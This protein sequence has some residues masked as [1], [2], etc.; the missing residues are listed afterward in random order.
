MLGTAQKFSPQPVP[1]AQPSAQ[2]DFM[3]KVFAYMAGG[4]GIT[5]LTAFLVSHSQTA[6]EFLILNRPVFFGLLIA[7][8]LMVF[9]FTGMARRM[10]ASNAGILFYC[11]AILNGITLSVVF[12]LYTQASIASTFVVSAGT[13]GAMS[14]YGFLTKRDLTSF[15][16]F[17]LMGLFGLIL[18]SIVNI[19][20]HSA[21]IYWLT[22]F[23][24]VLVF[25][26][27]TAY[28]VQKI[29][30]LNDGV[31]DSE[32]THKSAIHGALVLYLD[33]INM[34]LY[35]LRLLGRRR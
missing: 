32:Q 3:A 28:D 8:L 23:M 25:T 6:L 9:A 27:L 33:F 29:K 19:F 4:L 22:T 2:A 35:L 13:F 14:L 24:G 7:E 11:Y 15:G 5:A 20:M 1:M 17:L 18:A 31:Y 26:G 16:N 30:G 21:T 12:L 10:S 34:F